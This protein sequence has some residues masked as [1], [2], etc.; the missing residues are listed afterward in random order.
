MSVRISYNVNKGIKFGFHNFGLFL[1]VCLNTGKFWMFVK[2]V[3]DEY[4][5]SDLC[6]VDFG[7]NA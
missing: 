4:F 6:T 1:S 3:T 2:N 5:K 7:K